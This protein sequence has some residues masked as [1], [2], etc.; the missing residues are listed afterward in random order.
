MDEYKNVSFSRKIRDLLCRIT[1][2]NKL[3]SI[4]ANELR[5][6][7]SRRGGEQQAVAKSTLSTF[8][9]SDAPDWRLDKRAIKDLLFSRAYYAVDSKEYFLFGLDQSKGPEKKDYVG[10]REL[11]TYYIEL[12]KIGSP[13]VFERKE[14]TY[15]AFREFY[16]RKVLFVSSEAQKM[17]MLDFLDHFHSVIIKPIDD[18]GGNGV[19]IIRCSDSQT[20]E[21]IWNRVS[22]RCPFI[23]EEL[24]IQAP[25]MDVFYPSAV[26]TIRYNTF[27]HEGK[28]TKMQAVFHVGRG[29][30]NIDSATSGGIYTLVNPE[31]GRILCPARSDKG[32]RFEKHPDTGTTFKGNVIPRWDELNEVLEKVVRVVPEQKQ[33]GWDFALSEDG[34]VMVEGNTT[35][36]LQSFDL[37][38]GL[39]ELVT[40]TFGQVIKMWS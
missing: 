5:Y 24:I 12:N 33:V 21:Q 39:R 40:D 17:E 16:K 7:L 13:D 1:F 3:A 32:E 11:F 34:W 23:L 25:E 2:H 35:P 28:L 9:V 22:T 18:Y 19:E 36:A 14:K 8:H 38:H 29:G 20:P 30:S 27:F 10:W 37:E 6:Y 15:D 4:I 26:N 31:S